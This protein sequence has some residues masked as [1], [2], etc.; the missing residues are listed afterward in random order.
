MALLGKIYKSILCFFREVLH[1][2]NKSSNCEFSLVCCY[3]SRFLRFSIENHK[4]VTVIWIFLI[5]LQVGW[6]NRTKVIALIL[7]TNFSLFTTAENSP[8]IL[9][10][11]PD[12]AL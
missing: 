1:T 3:L 11:H 10:L 6:K 4:F 5:F 2:E 12:V 9:D 7:F 8:S